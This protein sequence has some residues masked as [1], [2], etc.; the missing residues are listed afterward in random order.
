[1]TLAQVQAFGSWVGAHSNKVSST[2]RACYLAA[3]ALGWTHLTIEQAGAVGLAAESVLGLFIESTTV[4]KQRAGERI[5]AE[6]ERKAEIKAD[7][8]VAQMMDSGVFKAPDGSI[9]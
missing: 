5:E 4:S 7:I 3:M 6:S 2:A 8:K 9:P 1:M